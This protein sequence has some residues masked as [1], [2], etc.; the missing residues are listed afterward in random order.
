MRI[1]ITGSRDWDEPGL[2]RVVLDSYRPAAIGVGDCPTGVDRAA[3]SWAEDYAYAWQR[4]EADW[5]QHGK[6][7]GPIRNR[8]MLDGWKPQ[9]LIAFKRGSASRG[10]DDCIKAAR[11]RS[12]PVLL[13]QRLYPE[14]A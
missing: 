7:A 5:K 4:Y 9:L 11:E 6:G 13:I 8:E 2:V 1:C 14:P 12:I 10:T 3:L